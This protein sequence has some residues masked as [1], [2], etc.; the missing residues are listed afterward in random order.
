M[1]VI[2]YNQIRQSDLCSC[3]LILYNQ[4]RQ[5]DLCSCDCL[6]LCKTSVLL[7]DPTYSSSYLH[8]SG[9]QLEESSLHCSL[10]SLGPREQATALYILQTKPTNHVAREHAFTDFRLF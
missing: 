8:N 2:L 7:V 1:N 9:L 5:S 6:G 3:D 4:I 10:S